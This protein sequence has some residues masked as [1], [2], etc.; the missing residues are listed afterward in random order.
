MES[1]RLPPPELPSTDYAQLPPVWKR[2]VAFPSIHAARWAQAL[3]LVALYSVPALV[4]ARM[5]T[6]ADPDLWWHLRS[7]EWITQHGAL[8]QTD[9]FS[10]FGAGKPW[11]AYSWLFEL[12]V[13]QL[14]H[15]FG[16]LGPMIYSAAMVASMTALLHRT[17]RH[18]QVDFT[19]GV[20]L[21]LTASLCLGRMYTPRPWWFTIVFFILEIDLLMQAR[22][23]GKLR[24]L[25]WLP[26][27]FAFWANVHIQL[28]YGL[29]VLALA[30]AESVLA[31]WWKG[32]QVRTRPGWMAG[33]FT[34]S[35]L[36][37]LANPYGWKIYKVA[38]DLASESGALDKVTELS[39]MSFRGPDDWGVLLFA[40]AA[41]AALAWWRSFAFFE[42]MLLAF[43]I[44]VSFRSQRDLWVLVIVASAILAARLKGDE[45]NRFQLPVLAAPF[46]AV[47]TGLVIWLGFLVLHMNQAQLSKKLAEG[48]P[49]RAVEVVKE[50]GWSGPLYNDY[51][52]GGYLIW[53]LR[54]PVA[55]DGRQNV[56]GDE[57][58]D[59][60]VSTWTGQ[61]DWNSDPDLTKAGLVIGSVHNPLIQ[62]LRM[63]PRFQLAYEDKLAAVFVA[64]RD[65]SSAPQGA[66]GPA[67]QA[68]GK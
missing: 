50:K 61:P 42:S 49:V 17:I 64:R 38:Y 16:L 20:L 40:L 57:R 32:I 18:L 24:G 2:P 53:A 34:A 29:A 60:S 15:W 55:I 1:L 6:I 9:P 48:L 63:D 30:L 54:M 27:I 62:L 43:A 11:I 68:T 59:R 41:T 45:K 3:I 7:A 33:V 51:A 58:L 39:S 44:Y 14:F 28:V 12:I 65:S 4:C 31:R 19:I 56:Y 52:W 37:T 35:L 21:A 26:L 46:M 36:A 67:L 10:V 23:N 47:G 25:L 22:K 13:F 66:S 5:G 8:P